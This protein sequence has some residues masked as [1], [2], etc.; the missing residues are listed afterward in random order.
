MKGNFIN[1]DQLFQKII[2]I[3]LLNLEEIVL[4]INEFFCLRL[5]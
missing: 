3:K 5:K 2:L 4:T 1:I